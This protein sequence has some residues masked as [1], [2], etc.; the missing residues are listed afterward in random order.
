LII[1]VQP[2]LIWLGASSLASGGSARILGWLGDISYCVYVLHIPIFIGVALV[3][4][5]IKILDAYLGVSIE[6][7]KL[8]GYFDASWPLVL[9][10]LPTTL[11]VSHFFTFNFD[12]PLRRWLTKR[13]F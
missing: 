4:G 12:L 10:A 5:D 9:I 11:L 13:M 1:I 8:D 6:P 2:F 7:E 3:A